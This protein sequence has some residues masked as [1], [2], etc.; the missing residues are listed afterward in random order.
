[1]K[2]PSIAGRLGRRPFNSSVDEALDCRAAERRLFNSSVDEA[3][4]R[5]A[6]ERRLFNSSVDEALRRR[7]RG[8][9]STLQPPG[10]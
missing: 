10:D 8:T 2:K 9:S 3:L 5:R 1:M 6:A 7:L 4:N